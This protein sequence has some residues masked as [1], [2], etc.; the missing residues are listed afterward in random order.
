MIPSVLALPAFCISCFICSNKCAFCWIV[1]KSFDVLSKCLWFVFCR[2]SDIILEDG[3]GI[4]TQAFLDSCYAIVPVLG[5]PVSFSLPSSLFP[6]ICFLFASCFL[7]V[8]LGCFCISSKKLVKGDLGT[9]LWLLAW[10]D[11]PC[12]T[13]SFF[14]PNHSRQVFLSLVNP[15]FS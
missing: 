8:S 4:P 6:C 5:R 15:L 11:S 13:V 2:F 14:L 1:N 12:A 10:V 3:S 7:P 9:F